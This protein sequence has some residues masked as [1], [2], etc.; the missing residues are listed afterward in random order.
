[1]NI[2]CYINKINGG[3]AERVMSVLVNELSAR[4]HQV[5]LV[6]DYTSTN[7][8]TISPNVTRSSM[9]GEF[10]KGNRGNVIV[11]TVRRISVLRKICITEQADIVISF[12]REAS[13][14]AIMATAFLKTKN[15]I[16][17]RIDPASAYHTK[18]QA[19]MAKFFYSKAEACVFQTEKALKWYPQRIQKHARVIINPIDDKFY[20][21]EEPNDRRKEIVSCGRL[22][23]QKRFDILID[24]FA[25]VL[26]NHP[27]FRLTIYGEGEQRANLE[28]KIAEYGIES[29]VSLPGRNQD[30][31]AAIH[32]SYTF[33]LSSDF[34][35]LPNGLM[36]AMA[37]GLPVIATDCKGGGARVVVQNE[38]HGLLVPTGNVEQMAA[39]LERYMDKEEFAFQM[40]A[41]ARN[42]AER[43]KTKA[44][45]DQWEAYVKET[46]GR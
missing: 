37:M 43:F 12:M 31:A 27:E 41:K 28:K 13:Y 9:D 21:Y 36:E 1:M 40:G 11:R 5:H 45:V 22:S 35:G 26:P 24:A 20:A 15:M 39:A 32:D 46:V 14:K 30:I 10:N 44:V 23:T 42:T 18:L 8:Y 2:V 7:E 19:F 33:V 3:G 4:G 6:T 29:S 34:E 38:M 17:V 25:K 16:S